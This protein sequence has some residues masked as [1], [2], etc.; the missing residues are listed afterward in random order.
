MNVHRRT[1]IICAAF[2]AALLAFQ[3]SSRAFNDHVPSFTEIF[4]QGM[5]ERESIVHGLGFCTG[6]ATALTKYARDHI[7]AQYNAM[8]E[9][10]KAWF[11]VALLYLR[12][13][14]EEFSSIATLVGEHFQEM[15]A[16]DSRYGVAMD[17]VCVPLMQELGK[18]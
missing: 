14:M 2:S 5:S 9:N 13:D 1:A 15:M 6:T 12:G 10:L 16:Q 8:N 7:P 3:P 18:G 4:P 11:A 17:K